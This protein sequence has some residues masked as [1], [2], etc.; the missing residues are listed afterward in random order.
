MA[1]DMIFGAAMQSSRE[2]ARNKLKSFAPPTAED[3]AA[4]IPS[5][6]YGADSLASSYVLQLDAGVSSEAELIEKYRTMGLYAKIDK[7]VNEIT[8]EAIVTSED[9]AIVKLDL[10]KIDGLSKKVKQTIQ[11]EF[12]TIL[13]LMDFNHTGY[14]KFKRWY[15]DSRLPF[16]MMVDPDAPEK[17]IQELR[18]LDPRKVKRIKEIHTDKDE[19]G[20]ES[21]RIVA[22][23]YVYIEAATT[24]NKTFGGHLFG[25]AVYQAGKGPANQRQQGVT[26]ISKDAVAL[27]HSGLVDPTTGVIYGYLQKAI[28]P[29]NQLRM[30]EDS[31]IVYRLARAPERRIFYVD[32]GSLPP[33]QAEAY[34]NRMKNMYRSKVVY[35]ARTGELADQRR[36]MA[37]QEDF[38]LPRREGSRGTEIDTLP[39][40]E[41][42][43][44]ITDVN[45]FRDD[46]WDALEVPAARFKQ[47]GPSLFGGNQTQISQEEI[48][49][50][51]FIDRLR[52]QFSRV[53]HQILRVQLI[54]RNVLTADEWDEIEQEIRYVYQSSS[55]FS[56]A[57]ET[58]I[59]N[60]RIALAAELLPLMGKL[61]SKR[62]I[63]K[64]AFRLTDDEINE[65]IEEMEQDVKDDHER[66]ERLGIAPET[67]KLDNDG[68]PGPSQTYI[69][70]LPKVLHKSR[71]GQ[72]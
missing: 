27:C 68:M 53:F 13:G 23:Y 37:M 1:D 35:D 29:Y 57:K 67:S 64:R 49:F 61:V 17:G 66:A 36:T 9:G 18:Q 15:I 4:L 69:P 56:E 41:N 11:D 28:K 33:T 24:Y 47:E 72:L 6:G 14:E 30:L 42:L 26:K 48:K 58:E 39:G 16:H 51:N 3:G 63:W 25:D 45:Y 19:R 38:F 22:D 52:L 40:G 50:A 71:D 44:E 43:G 46:L 55:L 5:G 21:T 7:A 8:N 31:L 70:P 62:F 10:E 2:E 12:T 34:M 60:G 54:L 65:M 32:T 20:V 59:L